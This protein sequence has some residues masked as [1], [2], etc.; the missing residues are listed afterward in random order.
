MGFIG[1][2]VGTEAGVAVETVGAVFDG[3]ACHIGVVGTDG[4]D[5]VFAESVP[6]G[7][8]GLVAGFVVGEPFAG[9]VKVDIAEKVYYL[10][11]VCGG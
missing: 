2:L 10:L 11:H 7:L 6:L 8:H 9:V 1:P 3:E 4:S 5:K